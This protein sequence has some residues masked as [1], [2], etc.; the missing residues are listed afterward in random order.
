MTC[1]I[2]AALAEAEL[3]RSRHEGVHAVHGLV[4]AMRICRSLHQEGGWCPRTARVFHAAVR[5][6]RC[7]DRTGFLP[8]GD[9][10]EFA[11]DDEQGFE[12]GSCA[13]GTMERSWSV[14]C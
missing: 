8:H 3:I 4:T 5:K 11:T 10:L 2:D 14:A 9:D 1:E 6:L 13:S 7:L 12:Q